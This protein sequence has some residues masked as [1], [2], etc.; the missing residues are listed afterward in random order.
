MTSVY[1]ARTLDFSDLIINEKIP[2][3]MM[4]DKTIYNDLYIRYLGKTIIK[5]QYGKKHNCI[6]ISPLLIEGTIFEEGEFMEVY[7]TDDKNRIPIYIEAHIII[8]SIKVYMKSIKNNK[9][10]L[11]SN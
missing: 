7:V 8:G 2:L 10:P 1:Y 4:V 9:F 6:K 11:G 5:D 3:N